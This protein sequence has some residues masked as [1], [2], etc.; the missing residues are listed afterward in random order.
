[1][2][3]IHCKE[4][5]LKHNS[6]YMI[7]TIGNNTYPLHTTTAPFKPMGDR[8]EYEAWPWE[9]RSAENPTA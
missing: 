9:K 2:Y 8:E 4:I 3:R 7:N 6:N 5:E 1:M